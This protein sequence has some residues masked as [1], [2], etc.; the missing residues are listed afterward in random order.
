M[1]AGE[2]EASPRTGGS[3]GASRPP[4]ANR[5]VVTNRGLTPIGVSV[6]W[7]SVTVSTEVGKG[8]ILATR[9]DEAGAG[10]RG[11]RRSERR[12]AMGGR[13]WRRWE[14]VTPSREW[15][16]G[17]EC[18][19]FSG[20]AAGPSAALLRGKAGVR[21]SRVDVAWDFGVGDGLLA[22]EVAEW[23]RAGAE[24]RGLSPGVSGESGVNTRYWGSARSGRRIRIYRKD[25][26]SPGWRELV[27]PTMR[28]EV[29]LKDEWARGWWAAW[30]G[31][32]QAGY[33]AAAGCVREMVEM[34]VMDGAEV[35]ESPRLPESTEAERLAVFVRQYAGQVR[36]WEVAGIDVWGMLRGYRAGSRMAGSR[37]SRRLREIAESGGGQA[38]AE[39]AD[40]ILN[41]G[42]DFD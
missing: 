40:R 41:W 36:A 15:G 27:G 5:G 13:C 24:S 38:V 9:E 37:E 28:I 42:R 26:E 11:F 33:R 29:V 19:E 18:W 1:I 12:L 16:T 2:V 20:E 7:L 4:F 8:L 23:F 14:P 32:D 25:L 6:D 3:R 17:Y 34:D 10:M 22:D 21:P 30:S 35:M 39:L 31:G